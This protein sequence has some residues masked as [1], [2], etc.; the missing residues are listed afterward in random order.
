LTSIA[1]GGPALF[2]ANT[3]K[4]LKSATV[5][6]SA[7]SLNWSQSFSGNASLNSGANTVAVTATDGVPNVKSNNYQ[8]GAKGP[9]SATPTYDAN[10]NMTSDG[11]NSFTW[12]AE[13]RL[14][15][16]TYLGSGNNTQFT[17]DGFSGLVKIVETVSSSVTSSKQ[18][19]RCGS[20]ICEERNAGGTLVKQF[21][22]RGETISATN[23]F[24]TRDHLGSVRDMT[25]SSGNVQAHYEYGMW[26]EQTKTAGALDADFGYAGYYAHTRSGLNLTVYRAHRPTLG[27]W[28]NR[29]PLEED[30]GL[31]LFAYVTN[32]PTLLIDPLGLEGFGGLILEAARALKGHHWTPGAKQCNVLVNTALVNSGAIKSPLGSV[33]GID[34]GLGK[35]PN[36]KC[37]F[38]KTSEDYTNF[39][40]KDG[41]VA[42][43]N[44]SKLIHTGI[45]SA[46]G[47]QVYAGSAKGY[48]EIPQLYFTDDPQYGPPDHIYRCCKKK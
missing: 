16:I 21:F 2:Q 26:G 22:G 23:Y 42:V 41:D 9:T 14:T 30:G 6:G 29:D 45:L 39:T 10:G 3:N 8:V 35:D 38:N 46:K 27:R 48:S 15:Q 28:I 44:N 1:A 37:C 32:S 36:F 40:P 12:D 18:F 17:Y 19:V 4:A 25:D 33:S 24:Y 43:W 13:N 34:Q 11:T 7:A 31:N 5:A 47:T 20:Q